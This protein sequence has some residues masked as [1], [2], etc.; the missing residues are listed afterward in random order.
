MV[1]QVYDANCDSF[2]SSQTFVRTYDDAYSNHY[3]TQ[4]SFRCESGRPAAVLN[5]WVQQS[6]R[7]TGGSPYARLGRRRIL[8]WPCYETNKAC[9]SVSEGHVC[10]QAYDELWLVWIY[11]RAN[12]IAVVRNRQRHIIVPLRL[13]GRIKASRQNTSRWFRSY[14]VGSIYT[15][16]NFCHGWWRIQWSDWFDEPSPIQ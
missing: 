9:T 15:L 13:T 14:E 3:E 2:V 7:F 10:E 16:F 12:A 6:W 11:I 8:R 4:D 5:S 1:K